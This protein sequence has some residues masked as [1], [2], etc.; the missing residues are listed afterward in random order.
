MN[1]IINSTKVFKDETDNMIEE[2]KEILK[3]LDNLNFDNFS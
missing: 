3:E 1:D 2:Y